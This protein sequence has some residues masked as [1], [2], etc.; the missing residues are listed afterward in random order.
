MS[1][2]GKWTDNLYNVLTSDSTVT[3]STC[4]SLENTDFIW[5]KQDLWPQR[6]CI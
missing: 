2:D 6:D 1:K 3:D 4:D 5:V